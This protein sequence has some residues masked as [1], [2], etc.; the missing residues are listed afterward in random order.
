MSPRVFRENSAIESRCNHTEFK[1]KGGIALQ[2]LLGFEEVRGSNHA[3]KGGTVLL[4]LFTISTVFQLVLATERTASEPL[5]PETGSVNIVPAIPLQSEIEICPLDLPDELFSGVKDA[6]GGQELNRYR[7]C[8]VLAAW[9][10]AAHARAALRSLKMPV[11]DDSPVLPDDSQTCV[12]HLQSSLQRR[13]IRIPQPNDT[14]DPVQCFCGIRLHSLSLLT[15]PQAF[16]VTVSARRRHVKVASPAVRALEKNCRTPSYAGCSTCLKSL[17]KLNG[18]E[19]VADT[20]DRTNRINNRG[21]ELL[22]LTW[23][24][25]KNRTAYI[26]TVSAVFRAVMYSGLS[27]QTTVCTADPERMPLP[28]DSTQLDLSAGSLINPAAAALMGVILLILHVTSN[29]VSFH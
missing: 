6:C 27:P 14:C 3:M 17:Q 16:N 24:L 2:G 15:C 23:L 18:M 5:N 22:G 12:N 28:V 11:S 1:E 9:L 25:A 20:S 29:L 4:G 19:E 8:P 21:C 10:Y 26:P 13:G 7:C